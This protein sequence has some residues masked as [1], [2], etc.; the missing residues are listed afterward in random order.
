MNVSS[1]STGAFAQNY[2]V[3]VAKKSQ[4]VQEANGKSAVQLI[5]SASAPKLQ[6]GQTINVMA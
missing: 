2:G 3:A 1:L 5:E 6:P 4:D